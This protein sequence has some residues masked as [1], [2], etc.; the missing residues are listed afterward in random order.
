MKLIDHGVYF[1][2]D[3]LIDAAAVGGENPDEFRNRTMAYRIMNAH[4]SRSDDGSFH[5]RF[6]SM[7]SHDITYVGIIQTAQ[8][9]RASCRERV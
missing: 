3:K 8:I 6:D 2:G 4:S 7:V 9:G 1:S 5:I